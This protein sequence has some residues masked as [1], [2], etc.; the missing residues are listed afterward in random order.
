M[1]EIPWE[2][3]KCKFLCISKQVGNKLNP[4]KNLKEHWNFARIL[5]QD[6]QQLHE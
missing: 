1:D 3:Q 4:A 6:Y 2:K 5:P